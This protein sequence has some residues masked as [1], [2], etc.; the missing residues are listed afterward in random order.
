[1]TIHIWWSRKTR[2]KCF[3]ATRFD[4]FCISYSYF[5]AIFSLNSVEVWSFPVWRLLYTIL[6]CSVPVKNFYLSRSSWIKFI[7]RN[8]TLIILQFCI[9]YALVFIWACFFFHFYTFYETEMLQFLQNISNS[10]QFKV[11]E[12]KI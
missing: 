8:G 2:L 11:N 9:C 1:M 4:L 3:A 6:V 12:S 7:I 10:F 5:W